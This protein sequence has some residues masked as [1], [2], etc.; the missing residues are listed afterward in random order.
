ME[1]LS[2]AEK[3]TKAILIGDLLSWDLDEN[4]EVT[5]QAAYEAWC[6]AT[7]NWSFGA[8]EDRRTVFERARDAIVDVRNAYLTAEQRFHVDMALGEMAA[9]MRGTPCTDSGDEK[10]G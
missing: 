10:H 8:D 5:D 4:R 3:R 1:A 2:V 9:A 7:M 6:A